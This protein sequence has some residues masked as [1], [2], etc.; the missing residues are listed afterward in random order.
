MAQIK[1]IDTRLGRQEVDLSKVIHFPRGIIGY[2]DRKEFTLLQIRPDAPFLVLQCMEDPSLGLLVADPYGFM[3][4]YTIKVGDAEQK[5]LKIMK[6]EEL[7]VLVTVAIPPGRPEQ[8][9]LSLTGPILIN[10]AEKIGIQAPQ[11]D[12]KGPTKLLLNTADL[13]PIQ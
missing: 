9:V 3:P 1:E 2:E 11:T 12:L 7:A 4:E 8:T 6:R 10:H 13:T 5:L